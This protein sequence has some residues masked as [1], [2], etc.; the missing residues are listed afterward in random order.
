MAWM[1][2]PAYRVGGVGDVVEEG[3]VVQTQSV[4]AQVA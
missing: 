3:I 1:V 4:E 2:A